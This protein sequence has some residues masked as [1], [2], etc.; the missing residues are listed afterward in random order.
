MQQQ[1][2]QQEA[3]ID[4]YR[5]QLEQNQQL[6]AT[7]LRRMDSKEKRRS[8][9][10]LAAEAKAKAEAAAASA[11]SSSLQLRPQEVLFFVFKA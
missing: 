5:K 6:V 11:P 4:Q 9:A 1:Q 2:R 10:E 7:M 3:M 8:D